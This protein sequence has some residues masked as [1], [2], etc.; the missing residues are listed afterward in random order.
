M[1][2]PS[3]VGRASAAV[4]GLRARLGSRLGAAVPERIRRRGARGT[5]ELSVVMVVG[6]MVAGVVFGQGITR[7]AVEIADGLTWLSDSPSGR[8]IQV[9]PATGRPEVALQVGEEGDELELVQYDGRMYVLNRTTGALTAYDLTSILRSGQRRITEGGAV[10]TLR[11]PGPDGALLLVDDETSTI[12]AID[13]V[14]TASIG[15]TWVSA[16]GLADAAVDD[17]GTVWALEDDGSL[18]ELA[19]DAERLELRTTATQAVERSGP[20]SVLV[21]HPEGVTVFGPDQG[22]VAQVGTGEDTTAEAPKLVGELLAPEHA[23]AELVPVAAPE[24]S[25]VA[26]LSPGE[27]REVSLAPVGCAEPGTPEVFHDVVYVPCGDGEKVV[28]LGSDGQRVGEDIPTPGADPELVLDDDLLIINT[29]GTPE[30]VVV[31]GDGTTDTI[32]RDDPDLLTTPGL[33]TGPGELQETLDQ[34]LQPLLGDG[35]DRPQGEEGGDLPELRPGQPVGQPTARPTDRPTDRPTGRPEERPSGSPGTDPTGS[36]SGTPGQP[37]RGR[38]RCGDPQSPQG[39]PSGTPSGSPSGSPSQSPTPPGTG[40]PSTGDPSPTQ[41]TQPTEPGGMVLAAP[42]CVTAQATAEGRVTVSWKHAGTPADAFVV[43]FDGGQDITRV[44]GEIRQVQL[45]VPPGQSVAFVVTAVAEGRRAE[46]A[47]SNIVT[48]NGAP[49]EPTQVTGGA[50]Y[51]PTGNLQRFVVTVRWG[52]APANGSEVTRYDVSVTTPDG[53]QDVSVGGAERAA[54]VEWSC[55]LSVDAACQVGGDATASVTA[56]NAVGAGR[57]VSIQITGPQQPPPALPRG[58]AAVATRA[59]HSWSGSSLE[60]FGQTELTLAP[61]ADWAAFSGTCEWRH[62]GN[63]SGVSSGPVACDATSLTVQVQNG[64]ARE[65]D[66]GV[67]EHSIVFLA[68]N[69]GGAVESRTFTW[70]TRQQVLCRNCQI[71]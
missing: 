71:P 57:T 23:P 42:T 7:T 22:I 65:P 58:G 49:G 69:A 50:E 2:T 34:L 17:A 62:T 44:A 45:T 51:A 61:P 11:V 67:R 70:T 20:G 29:P 30:A 12:S 24:S 53:T 14:S 56:V 28:R 26:L 43:A 1:R 33:P 60:G 35:G 41:P 47:P 64:I 59:Q 36:P 31:E 54:S 32:V 25:T 27:L 68:S 66:D 37:C 9:N 39:T 40:V 6:A 3:R 46:S 4:G 5:A 19:W 10:H 16:T 38:S 63:R 18:H 13:P 55:D 52:A 48:T 15:T 8:V 21:A